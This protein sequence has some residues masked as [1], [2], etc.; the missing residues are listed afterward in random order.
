MNE[1]VNTI[2]IRFATQKQL[3][4]LYCITKKDWRQS[5]VSFDEASKL[6]SEHNKV[7]G[8]TNGQDTTQSNKQVVVCIEQEF[9]DYMLSP[10]VITRLVGKMQDE[11]CISS[12]VSNDTSVMKENKHYLFLG[13]GCGFSH[14]EYDKRGKKDIAEKILKTFGVIRKQ[15]DASVIASF[16][17]ESLEKLS[18]SGNPIQA[19]LFQNLA[20]NTRLNYI[21]AGFMEKKG[22]KKVRVT[23]FYD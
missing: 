11:M 21:V 15:I 20:F 14:I 3:W 8:L 22:I 16:S 18:G 23:S 17:T 13:G 2:A 5:G 10:Y 9:K 4:A 19:H 6:I 7:K 12:V 1:N